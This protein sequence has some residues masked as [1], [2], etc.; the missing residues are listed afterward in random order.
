MINRPLVDFTERRVAGLREDIAK[1]RDDGTLT[2][3]ICD[4]LL[5][6]LDLYDAVTDQAGRDD[7]FLQAWAMRFRL[8]GLTMPNESGARALLP[9]LE[10][11]INQLVMAFP[12]EVP[13]SHLHTDPRTQERH[14]RTREKGKQ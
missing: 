8:E 6:V 9:G 12:D 14:V 7:S 2:G 4:A 3:P 5:G 1:A 13:P 10:A 11:A